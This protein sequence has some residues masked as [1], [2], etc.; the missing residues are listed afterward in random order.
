MKPERL[1]WAFLTRFDVP[2]YDDPSRNFM[3]RWRIIQ[4]PWCALYLHRF[5]GPDA[6]P[7]L[8]DHPW[9][10]R[11]LI[12]WGGYLEATRYEHG[13]LA[14]LRTVG[15][16]NWNR[17]RATDTHVILRLVRVPTWTL[18]FVGRRERT[19]GYLDPDG[20]WTPFDQH[21]HNQE[22]EAALAARAKMR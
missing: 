2:D 11:S 15:R 18:M 9:R 3:T 20:T 6:R 5:D 1:R 7:T 22:Y 14:G 19:W 12:L 8:H 4:T 16:W 21:R 10:F 17:K 13:R